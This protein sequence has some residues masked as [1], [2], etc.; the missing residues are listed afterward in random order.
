MLGLIVSL[1]ICFGIPIGGFIYFK[2]KR[3]GYGR[4][5]LIGVVTFVVSQIILRIP[6]LAILSEVNW[7]ISFQLQS[8]F[9]FLFV[10]GGISAGIFEEVAR[11]IG[12]RIGYK[13]RWRFMDAVALGLGHGGIEAILLVGINHIAI[14]FLFDDIS[15][16]SN[17]I[18]L[19]SFER[20]FLMV[21]HIAF[22]IILLYFMKKSPLLAI[23]VATIAHAIYN[24]T[25]V[26]VMT[27][28]QNLILTLLTII[29]LT[30]ILAFIC[31]K[32]KDRFDE[33]TD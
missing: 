16:Y 3:D 33:E 7:F 27:T 14:V 1:L 23:A 30:C 25:A 15:A 4:L 13:K 31:Y 2:R 17:E 11:Y 28:T 9:L 18:L 19:A 6:L 10:V 21:A 20:L 26:A 32:I 8:P 24:F 12:L 22:T 29:G 5:F